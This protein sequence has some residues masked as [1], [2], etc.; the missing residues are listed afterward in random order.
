MQPK[1]FRKILD[2]L[3]RGRVPLSSIE[4]AWKVKVAGR[5]FDLKELEE[6]CTKFL[7]YRID[8]KNLVHFLKN[9]TKYDT[10]D[11]R[12]V[13]ISRFVKDASNGFESEQVL[14]LSEEELL[15]IMERKPE[16]QAKKIMEVLIRW[17]R[18]WALPLVETKPK[19]ESKD[20][21][22]P[23]KEP[24]KKT[25][26]S[27]PD[28]KTSS[29]AT[30]KESD[31]ADKEKETEADKDDKVKETSDKEESKETDSGKE[32]KEEKSEEG[33]AKK[34][35][36]EKMEVDEKKDA[37]PAENTPE[38]PEEDFIIPLQQL[39]KHVVWDNNDA[40]YYL[41]EAHNKKIL[42]EDNKNSAMAQMLQAFVD[43]PTPTAPTTPAA[44][45]MGPKSVQQQRASPAQNRNQRGGQKRAADPGCEVVMERISKNPRA[46]QSR[47]KSEED[48]LF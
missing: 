10:P 6:L 13:V 42:A 21:K 9:T 8:A 7:K 2:Y 36:N 12:E 45:R 34:E 16:I 23:E 31:K 41:K 5:T 20:E 17:A 25:E 35:D 4:D 18:K 22:V 1:T 14:E 37:K 40:E 19:E 33:A 27:K 28:E 44:A 32:K 48:M 38:E 46:A 47:V 26:E 39:V 3:F 30:D 11:L 43:L 15:S 24:E 29:E